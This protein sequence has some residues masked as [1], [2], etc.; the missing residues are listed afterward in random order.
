MLNDVSLSTTMT[1][2]EC[3]AVPMNAF[4]QNS[5]VTTHKNITYKDDIGFYINLF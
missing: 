2:L 3:N 4:W 1:G 5:P